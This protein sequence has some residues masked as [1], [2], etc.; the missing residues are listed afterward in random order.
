VA[1]EPEALWVQKA[2]LVSQVILGFQD[3]QVS[4]AD[5]V[6]QDWMAGKEKWV[7]QEILDL[8]QY[9]AKKVSEEKMVLPAW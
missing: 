3:S 4:M 1:L 8:Q 6:Y 9:V 2:S 5:Q 7:H